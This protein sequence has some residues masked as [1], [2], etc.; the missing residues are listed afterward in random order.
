MKI[1]KGLGGSSMILPTITFAAPAVRKQLTC[2][3]I[4]SEDWAQAPLEN[5]QY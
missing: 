1:A 2:R 4:C 5:V 3:K